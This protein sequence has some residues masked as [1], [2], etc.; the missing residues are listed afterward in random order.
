MRVDITS[1]GLWLLGSNLTLAIVVA[2]GWIGA[3]PAAQAQPTLLAGALSTTVEDQAD[4]AVT[5]YN[6]DLALV[7]D[8]RTLRLPDGTFDLR[9]EDIAGS[10]NP[11]T[12]HVRSLSQPDRLRV[13]EQNFEYDLLDPDKLLRKYVG[14]DVTLVRTRQEDGSSR[15]EEVQAR[16]LAFNEGPV[17]Q[18]G[19]EIVTGLRSDY[20]RFPTLPENLYD[21]PTLIWTLGNSGASDH[22]V[23][24]SYLAGRVSW[25]ADYVLT[26]ARDAATADLD[27]WVTLTNESGTAFMNASL[28]L[29]AGDLNR[30]VQQSARRMAQA[31]ALQA[32]PAAPAFQQEAFADYHLYTLGRRTSI[33]NHETK[34]LSLLAGSGIPTIKR[35]VVEG[36]QAYYRNAQHP[37]SPLRDAVQVQYRLRNDGASGLGTPL[38]AGIVRVYQADSSGRIQFAG[39]DRI[40]HTPKDELLTLHVGNAFDVVCE[41]RQ[42]DFERL[43]DSTYE[44]AFEIVLRNHKPTP[45]E[46][47]L[48]EPLGG[49]WRMLESTHEVTRTSAWSAQFT[50][51]VEA[52]GTTQVGYRVRVRW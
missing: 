12:V 43:G 40:T 1:N 22:R 18:I 2:I 32:V 47:E 3:G 41:R 37:G 7:R 34:Q 46:V 19:D 9:F 17:W 23:E 20:L 5:V 27:G 11:A 45:I 52:N 24:A 14:R 35:F 28:Q 51:P 26:I 10:V 44:L 36:R 39:E 49:D 30:V 48:H 33:R 42:T 25:A 31:E 15:N 50:V 13:L 38:P 8:I 21:R 29:V 4:L 16:L 6:T